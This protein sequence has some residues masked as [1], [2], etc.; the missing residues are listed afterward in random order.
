MF[1]STVFLNR[2][3]RVSD[4]VFVSLRIFR[5]VKVKRIYTIRKWYQNLFF[6]FLIH[7]SALFF[8]TL[9]DVLLYYPDKEKSYFRT[10]LKRDVLIFHIF[11]KKGGDGFEKRFYWIATILL[12]YAR[13]LWKCMTILFLLYTVRS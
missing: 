12:S 2:Y 7:R 9:Y 10:Y 1:I 6:S 11:W 13:S 4:H 3:L 8:F 5:T